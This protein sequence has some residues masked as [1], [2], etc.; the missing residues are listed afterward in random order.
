MNI[1][2]PLTKIPGYEVNK[3][4]S[5]IDDRFGFHLPDALGW[6][7]KEK[8][9]VLNECVIQTKFPSAFYGIIFRFKDENDAL[10]FKLIWGEWCLPPL[11]AACIEPAIQSEK[12]VV[13][14]G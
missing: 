11:E 2:L 8:T 3:I 1:Y 9:Y 7:M 6:E 5:W 14:D 12:E 10:M 13:F 4:V